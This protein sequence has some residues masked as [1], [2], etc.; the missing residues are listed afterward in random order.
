MRQTVKFQTAF[1]V[2]KQIG[3]LIKKWREQRSDRKCKGIITQA[4]ITKLPPN[5]IFLT[6][7]LWRWS[8][9]CD[10]LLK[11]FWSVLKIRI[12][13]LSPAS[14]QY[15]PNKL[16]I[17]PTSLVR[18]KSFSFRY[19]NESSSNAYRLWGYF[20][21]LFLMVVVV[22]IFWVWG[23]D[24]EQKL[25]C[26][27]DW[28][29]IGWL[30]IVHVV[31]E[32]ERFLSD[33]LIGV[34]ELN[35]EAERAVLLDRGAHEQTTCMRDQSSYQHT[36]HFRL[37]RVKDSSSRNNHTIHTLFGANFNSLWVMQQVDENL[38]ARPSKDMFYVFDQ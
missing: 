25:T 32:M 3:S 14:S 29:A 10:S 15:V 2:A 4:H 13:G 27:R 6:P 36:L 20:L 34:V 23:K 21:F 31:I 35:G 9:S 17:K 33:V 28:E 12:R 1:K 19:R 8:R 38:S 37:V 5:W 16:Q 30:Q 26:V 11:R 24:K 22:V 18:I 7:T